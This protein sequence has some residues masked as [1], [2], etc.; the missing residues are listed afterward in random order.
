MFPTCFAST[1]TLR[2]E[3]FRCGSRRSAGF[4]DRCAAVCAVRLFSVEAALLV[5]ATGS[6]AVTKSERPLPLGR[7]A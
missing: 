4:G 5:T 2:A 7:P 6:V 1:R 3:G